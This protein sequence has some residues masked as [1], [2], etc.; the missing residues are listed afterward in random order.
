[1]TRER[2]RQGEVVLG[3]HAHLS[4]GHVIAISAQISQLGDLVFHKKKKK[5]KTRK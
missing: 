1:M 4:H 2:R 5:Q 3:L